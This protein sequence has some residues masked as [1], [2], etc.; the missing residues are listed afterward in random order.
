METKKVLPRD[1]ARGRDTCG[2]E[3]HS[4]EDMWEEELTGGAI[5]SR[6]NWYAL[7]NLYWSVGGM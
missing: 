3:Y 6:E 7:G 5:G 4:L 1:K 2:Q